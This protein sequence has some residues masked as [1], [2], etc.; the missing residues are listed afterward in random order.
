[1]RKW[2]LHIFLVSVL[3]MLTASCSQNA[4][5]PTQDVPSK[6]AD[7]EKVTIRFTID[8]GEQSGMS[9]RAAWD[10]YDGVGT[11]QTD[12]EQG[13]D[14]PLDENAIDLTTLQVFIL[15]NKGTYIG[16][17]KDMEANQTTTAYIYEIEGEVDVPKSAIGPDEV[18]GCKI[19]VVANA[20]DAAVKTDGK[21]NRYNNDV[22][23]EHSVNKIPMWGIGTYEIDL[24]RQT[25]VNL[26]EP[27]YML[28]S[29]AKVEVTLGSTV[30][31]SYTL[32]GARLTKYNTTGYVVPNFIIPDTSTG[33]A[34]G[35][36]KEVTIAGFN[37]TTDLTTTGVFREYGSLAGTE[38][39]P[40]KKEFTQSVEGKSYIIYVP[41]FVNSGDLQIELD[42][43]QGETNIFKEGENKY[44]IYL[45]EYKVNN[46]TGKS[47]PDPNKPLN[48]IRNHWYRYTI[49]SIEN[50]V[51]AEITLS[52]T[53]WTTNQSSV[54]Y[55]QEAGFSKRI[56]W[57][58]DITNN[59]VVLNDDNPSA[60]FSFNLTT[61]KDGK[62]YAELVHVNGVSDAFSFN[63][64]ETDSPRLVSGNI[65]SQEHTLTIVAKYLEQY[66][67]ENNEFLLKIYVETPAL[68]G[69]T[70]R[71]TDVTNLLGE[72][73]IKQSKPIE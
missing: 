41:E 64:A 32:E 65:N 52:V 27:I 40:T 5:D 37:A 53:P 63:E 71:R 48:L 54:D 46:S 56:T 62:W 72:Y 38:T 24:V 25:Q 8:L 12:A 31:D 34:A 2:L 35:A 58:N 50:G 7:T 17:L 1:M 39:N 70:P 16:G 59:D 69:T 43:K 36:I 73:T 57:T 30:D 33:A 66:L 45:N 42:L 14:T 26:L 49:N 4:D 19:M 10:G 9:S 13:V 67:T 3:G 21:I 23:F 51:D 18:L 61:P 60:S 20:K 6:S 29:M 47:E 15:D 22:D 11:D 44:T 55:R 68:D 28:R